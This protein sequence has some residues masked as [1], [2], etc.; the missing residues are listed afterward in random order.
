[1]R[2]VLAEWMEPEFGP[3][4]IPQ[5]GI[6]SVLCMSLISRVRFQ[7]SRNRHTVTFLKSIKMTIYIEHSNSPVKKHG[8]IIV[9][10]S[11][12]RYYKNRDFYIRDREKRILTTHY[13]NTDNKISQQCHT[14]MTGHLMKALDLRPY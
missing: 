3:G 8:Q 5:L 1:M 12:T 9:I 10:R 11:I 2:N 14:N 4:L 6:G 7:I 13:R